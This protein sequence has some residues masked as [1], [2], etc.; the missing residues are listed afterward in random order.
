MVRVTIRD[1]PDAVRDRL[2]A[3]AEQAGQ[4]MQEYLRALLIDL[5]DRP[6]N[7]ELLERARSAMTGSTVSRESILTAL[8]ADRR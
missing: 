2:A 1:V 8:R 4:S 5:G 7:A 6:T 3:R